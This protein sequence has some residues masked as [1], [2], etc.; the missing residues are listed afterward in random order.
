MLRTIPDHLDVSSHSGA[1][2]LLEEE[3]CD[4]HLCKDE[5][6]RYISALG[7]KINLISRALINAQPCWIFLGSRGGAWKT[8][9]L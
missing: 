4:S 9:K 7:D 3:L 2:S 5:L 1:V 6:C 8:S